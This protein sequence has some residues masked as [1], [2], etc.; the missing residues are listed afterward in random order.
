[1]DGVV[2]VDTQ[3]RD[4]PFSYCWYGRVGIQFRYHYGRIR[5]G[6]YPE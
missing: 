2:G 6:R 5:I 1:M 3:C 4:G